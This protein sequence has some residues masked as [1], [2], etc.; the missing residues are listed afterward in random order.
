VRLPCLLCLPGDLAR[1]LRSIV[2]AALFGD[3]D[4]VI[5]AAAE[6]EEIKREIFRS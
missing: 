4:M 6:R 2:H 3:C 1:Q 5:E